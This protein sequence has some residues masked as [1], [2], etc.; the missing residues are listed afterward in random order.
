VAAG[1]GS[2]P[3]T[4][5]S[6]GLGGA[7]G[8]CDLIKF[9]DGGTGT[10]GG[11]GG[12]GGY[13]GGGGGDCGDALGSGGGG[14]SSFVIAGAANVSMALSSAPPGVS[15]TYAA[16]TADASQT[17]LR[18]GTQAP[19]TAGPA[20]TL[21]VTNKG[22]APLVVSGVLLGGDDPDDFLVADRCQK[23]VAAG[24]SCQVGVRFD[25]QASGARSATL[26]L[27]TNAQRVPKPVALSGIGTGVSASPQ[28]PRGEVAVVSCEPIHV[29]TEHGRHGT[30]TVRCA[31]NVVSG[32]VKF[33][34]AGPATRA[35][36]VRG[37]AV[38]AV[39]VSDPG[40]RGGSRL[41]LSDRR[42]LKRGTYTLI[43][44]DRRGGHWVSQRISVVLG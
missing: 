12:G 9:D 33:S 5:G 44:R 23:P 29:G 3:G 25:P 28:R 30:A 14:G 24:S 21:T 19:G 37:R 36:I 42:P 40:G 39:G 22:S 17:A 43:L 26:T 4:S 27:L 34:G 11:G 6:F 2:H 41:V 10:G 15:I 35:T 38:F 32:R 1:I 20:Q 16:P 31:R 18:F 13:Y 8:G 7:G